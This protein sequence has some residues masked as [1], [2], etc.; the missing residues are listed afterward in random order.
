MVCTFLEY[1]L[2]KYLQKSC[3]SLSHNLYFIH[4][5]HLYE[6]G[7]NVLISTEIIAQ[8]IQVKLS[9]W[10]SE[11]CNNWYKLKLKIMTHLCGGWLS[12]YI[13]DWWQF[14]K[15]SILSAINAQLKN[16]W[17]T[18][19]DCPS[20]LLDLPHIDILFERHCCQTPA[21]TPLFHLTTSCYIGFWSSHV[22]L[23]WRT[24]KNINSYNTCLLW[25]IVHV[26]YSHYQ[27]KAI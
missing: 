1:K 6:L 7:K 24:C 11:H 9:L 5:I 19:L 26:E 13:H 25:Y 2:L 17:F 12:H 23:L 10:N 22:C 27:C 15:P 21:S 4:K 18:Q 8:T 3:I 16:Y 20:R 14:S